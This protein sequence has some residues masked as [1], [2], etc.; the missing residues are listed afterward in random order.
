MVPTLGSGWAD[1]EQAYESDCSSRRRKV[2]DALLAQALRACS[3]APAFQ[4]QR[5]IMRNAAPGRATEI[6]ESLPVQTRVDLASRLDDYQVPRSGKLKRARSSG[7]SGQPLEITRSGSEAEIERD[8]VE[9]AWSRMGILPGATGAVLVG[10]ALPQGDHKVAANGMLWIS[11][12]RAD[13]SVWERVSELL[14]MYRPE[15]VRGYGSLVGEYF[16][17]LRDTGTRPTSVSA[18]AYSSDYITPSHREAVRSVLGVE[19]IGLYGQT[20]RAVMALTCGINDQYHVFESYGRMELMDD[21]GRPIEEAGV[22]GDVVGTALWPR[23]TAIVR[24]GI[25]DRAAWVSGPCGCGRTQPRF[26]L[27]AA[28]KRDVLFDSNG[29]RWFFGPAIYEP[30]LDKLPKG[31][32]LQFFHPEPGVLVVRLSKAE[33]QESLEILKSLKRVLGGAFE[34]AI[35][36]DGPVRSSAGKRLLLMLSDATMS[37]T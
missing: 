15:Y 27:L 30:V 20:E 10:R 7:S 5:E 4:S 35:A 17:F 34:L 23:A 13:E 29:V 3:E 26:E 22:V 1:I 28:R 18:A 32:D 11:C 12:L 19:P 9:F 14:E 25:G 24:Y 31:C 6:L 33:P 21:A 8:F 37:I 16:S 36:D 2:T